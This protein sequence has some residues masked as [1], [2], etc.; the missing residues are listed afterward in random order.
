MH[1]IATLAGLAVAAGLLTTAPASA[2]AS[3]SYRASCTN[4]DQR[5]PVL[6]AMCRDV[7]G[8]L[9]PTQIDLRNCG[10]GG[11]ANVNGRLACGGGGGG[12]GYDRRDRDDRDRYEGRRRSDDRRRYD[13][14]YEPRSYRPR[15]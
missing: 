1:R 9:V 6:R 7:R 12:G 8:Q 3:G 5:G 13:E 11:V 10:G 15:Y 2:Q 14:E 4:I